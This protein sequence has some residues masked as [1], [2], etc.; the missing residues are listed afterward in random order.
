MKKHIYIYLITGVLLISY[1]CQKDLLDKKPLDSVSDNDV[2]ANPQNA[3]LFVNN[4][5]ASLPNGYDRGWYMLDAG[6]SDAEN[7]YAWTDS[8]VFNRGENDP[9]FTPNA[10]WTTSYIQI[11]NCNVFLENIDKV[12]GDADFIKTLKGEVLFL[13]AFYYAELHK[14]FGGVP[15]ITKVLNLDDDFL[16]DGLP[17]A[18]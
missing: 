9:S 18:R 3:S 2:F 12:T 11:K 15:L 13:R 8:H 14:R 10:D 1:S 7:S 5:Y 17:P 4:I 6:T 16:Q